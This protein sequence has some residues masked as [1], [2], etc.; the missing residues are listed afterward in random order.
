ML[1][2]SCDVLIGS[3]GRA[4]PLAKVQSSSEVGIDCQQRSSSKDAL[5]QMKIETW[6]IDVGDGA[7]F[8]FRLPW[9][10]QNYPIIGDAHN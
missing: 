1:K 6:T 9:Q 8:T 3:F 10:C 4:S 7:F 2:G 5:A